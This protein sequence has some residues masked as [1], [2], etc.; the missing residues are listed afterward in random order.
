M[1]RAGSLRSLA[2]ARTLSKSRQPV[3]TS[4]GGWLGGEPAPQPR[5]MLQAGSRGGAGRRLRSCSKRARS[6][7]VRSRG[8]D[9]PDADELVAPPATLHV[10]E[11]VARKPERPPAARLGRD[12]HRDLAAER[13]HLDLGAERGLPGGDRQLDVEIVLA[14]LEER[15]RRRRAP[16]GRGPPGSR[17]PCRSRPRRPRGPASRPGHRRGSSPRPG[18]SGA[19]GRSRRTSDTPPCP[20]VPCRGTSRRARAAGTRPS[21]GSRHGPL[22][23]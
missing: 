2:G 14:A 17:R 15:V 11:A 13:R 9:D 6:S 1:R 20:D 23:G 10:R 8:I 18:C 7:A 21:A 19:P 12:L 3:D 5:R 16:G 22:P 4:A